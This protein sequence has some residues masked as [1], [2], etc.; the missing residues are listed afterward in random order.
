M[1][2]H[3]PKYAGRGEQG[4]LQERSG[5]RVDGPSEPMATAHTK[6]ARPAASSGRVTS[7][8]SPRAHATTFA[9]RWSMIRS[10]KALT[11]T[12][13]KEDGMSRIVAAAVVF[14]FVVAGIATGSWA[15]GL[16]T[17]QKL[18]APLANELVGDT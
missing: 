16:V 3:R 11:G 6:L 13:D 18:S 7:C 17:M 10:G 2:W 8:T 15:Q 1:I 5:V 12:T 4:I 14:A 9:P